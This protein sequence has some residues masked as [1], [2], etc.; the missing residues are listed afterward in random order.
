MINV[1]IILSA[2]IA[3]KFKWITS[4]EQILLWQMGSVWLICCLSHGSLFLFKYFLIIV[5]LSIVICGIHQ[6]KKKKK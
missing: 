3:L 1:K 6:I 2:Y 4:N 5:N